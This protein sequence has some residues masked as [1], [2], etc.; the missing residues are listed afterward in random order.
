MSAFAILR[1]PAARLFFAKAK[2]DDGAQ[3]GAFNIKRPKRFTQRH[4]AMAKTCNN[5]S[6]K[7]PRARERGRAGPS[8]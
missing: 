2:D 4:S 6:S 1:S 7:W 5:Y 8:R 3:A